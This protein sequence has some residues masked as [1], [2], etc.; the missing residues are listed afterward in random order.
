MMCKV[1]YTYITQLKLQKKEGDITLHY[2]DSC[3]KAHSSTTSHPG[4]QIVY[5]IVYLTGLSTASTRSDF[6]TVTESKCHRT[7]GYFQVHKS[8]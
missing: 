3:Q 2:I 1:D 8:L 5:L 7:V 6:V 4:W